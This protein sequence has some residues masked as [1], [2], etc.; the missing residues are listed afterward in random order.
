[1]L[2]TW[3]SVL[4]LMGCG[5]TAPPQTFQSCTIPDGCLGVDQTT[6][7]CRCTDWKILSDD[8][9]PLKFLVAG[10]MIA[11]PG[12]QGGVTYGTVP[13][14]TPPGTSQLGTR[15][16][17]VLVDTQGTRTVLSAEVA[18][19]GLGQFAL[20]A[21]G[22][23]TVAVGMVPGDGISLYSGYD[24]YAPAVDQ[25]WVWVNP[26]LRLVKDAGGNLRGIWGWNGTCFWPPGTNGGKGC[27]G[28]SVLNFDVAELDGTVQGPA[29]NQAFLHTL[30]PAELA[31]IRGTDRLASNPTPTTDDLDAD[32][33][34]LRLGELYVDSS[35]SSVPGT[36][37]A[38]CAT[39]AFDEDF[40]VFAS[41]SIP[42]P[43]GETVVVEQ[44]WLSTTSSCSMQ[45][46]GLAAATSTPDCAV[47]ATAYVDRMF[48]TLAFVS[49]SVT[50]ACTAL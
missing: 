23:R 31:A 19:D 24:V 15:F 11:A 20:D 44:S 14:G 49:G 35:V 1:M 42:V 39:T 6:G 16:R 30:E 22:S 18:T 26:T 4:A 9:V 28:P 5:S 2:L 33:R 21:V 3:C 10:V 50:A 36:G 12:N 38:P 8:V 29:Y 45:S 43:G 27:S 32:P 17:A 41:T 13:T 47:S 37:W 34:F 40:P 48:G 46:P 25:L 7:V